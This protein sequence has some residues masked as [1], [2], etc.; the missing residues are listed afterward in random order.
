MF[1]HPPLFAA[2]ARN[3]RRSPGNGHPVHVMRRGSH[4]GARCRRASVATIGSSLLSV[5]LSMTE[6]R[7]GSNLASAEGA[8]PCCKAYAECSTS[9]RHHSV[10]RHL[11]SSGPLLL[12]FHARDGVDFSLS[13]RPRNSCPHRQFSHV[14]T[15]RR[16]GHAVQSTTIDEKYRLLR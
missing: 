2:S 7:V 8:S 4:R 1:P 15:I 10:A 6:T 3:S 13:Y 14:L 16:S 12:P 9:S 5:P 11:L